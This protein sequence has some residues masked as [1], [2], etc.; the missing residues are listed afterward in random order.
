[1]NAHRYADYMMSDRILEIRSRFISKFQSSDLL[2]YGTVQYQPAV[3]DTDGNVKA[4]HDHW[5]P[6]I[7]DAI[8]I[9]K[10]MLNIMHAGYQEKHDYENGICYDSH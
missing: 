8:F 6:T 7:D 1:M 10:S 9:G 3:T 2:P 4:S 5:L